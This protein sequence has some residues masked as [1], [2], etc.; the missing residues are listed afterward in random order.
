M[1]HSIFP[2]ESPAQ[3]QQAVAPRTI[4]PGRSTQIG[5]GPAQGALDQLREL[6]HANAQPLPHSRARP[7]QLG[8]LSQCSRDRAV[9]LGGG[10]TDI[11]LALT[12]SGALRS[13]LPCDAEI[14]SLSPVRPGI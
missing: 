2:H 8:T 14:Y 7:P 9:L 4:S 11:P 3:S 5:S 1:G 12:V 10:R 13:G 6:P